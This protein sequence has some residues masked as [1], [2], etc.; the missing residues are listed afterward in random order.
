MEAAYIWVFLAGM[1]TNSLGLAL[2]KVHKGKSLVYVDALAD[3][4]LKGV[5][6]RGDEN[7][8]LRVS[9]I[10]PDFVKEQTEKALNKGAKGIV[11][12]INSGGGA[13]NP[14]FEIAEYIK[15]EV[16]VPKV[17]YIQDTGASAAYLIA[18]ACDK[19]VAN[20]FSVVGSIGVIMPNFDAS[21]LLQKIG[22]KRNPIKSGDNKDFSMFTPL[23]ENQKQELQKG[24]SVYHNEFISFVAE[25]RGL[26]FDEIKQIADG[27]PSLATNALEH[28]LID[29]V[30]DLK[31]AVATLEEIIGG[32]F[33]N[34]DII[35]LPPI[36][37]KNLV[38]R[39]LYSRIDNMVQNYLE[40][41]Y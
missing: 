37:K 40:G 41:I 7:K 23:N 6:A 24:A 8:R 1:L 12:T 2:N 22:I 29:K 26:T 20:K 4:Q 21:E 11:Y 19:I 14:S 13:A 9:L 27:M 3:I 34:K 30:G 25:R 28:G 33:K 18:T 5:V 36:E 32:E 15:N 31:V 16:K 38:N 39:L 17:A 10:T 35:K